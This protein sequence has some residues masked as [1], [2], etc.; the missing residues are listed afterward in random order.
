[1]SAN[2]VLSGYLQSAGIELD[3]SA[4]HVGEAGPE[5]FV[6]DASQGVFGHHVDV[7]FDQYNVAGLVVGVQSAGSVGNDEP[8]YAKKFHHAHGKVIC[9][10]E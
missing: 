3:V 4:H 1:M 10:M 8:L 2:A 7:V 5:P 9:C 6:A